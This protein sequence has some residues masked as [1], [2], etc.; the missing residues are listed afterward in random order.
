MSPDKL[1]GLAL[2]REFSFFDVEKSVANKVLKSLKD[3]ELAGRKINAR[4]ADQ[5][6]AAP[7]ND[8]QSD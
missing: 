8:L 3:T 2:K 4:F 7:R 5:G 6:K 1:S